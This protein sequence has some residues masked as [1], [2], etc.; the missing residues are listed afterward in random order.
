MSLNINWKTAFWVLALFIVVLMPV[1]S[2]DY[3]QSGDEW[4]QIDYGKD[5]WN[6]FAK[7]DQQALDYSNKSLQ[8][9]KQELYGGLFDF[10][11]EVI[12]RITP[13]VP[14]LTLR[15]FFNA[16][17]GAMLMLFTGLL[18]RRLSGKWEVAFLAL[19]FM[20]FSPR[21]FGESMNNPK[22]IPFATGFT[23]GVYAIV[24]FLQDFPKKAWRNAILLAI[25]WGIAFGVR[26]AG[27]I[28]LVGYFVLFTGLY[29]ITNKEL[30]NLL[31]A[32]KNKL[33]KKMLLVLFAGL[34][35]GYIIGLAAW[36]W[37]LQS[38]ISNTLAALEEMTNRSVVLK[39]LFEGE[40][41]PNNNMPWYYEFKWILMTSPLIIIA[42]IGIYLLLVKAHLKR[43]GLFAV[44]VPVFVAFFPLLYMIYKHSS[45]HDTWRHVFF[46]Y[47]GWVVMSAM[48]FDFL[49]GLVKQ[50]KLKMLP[51]GVAIIGLLPVV[52]W[53]VR[54]HPNQYVYFNEAVGG[55]KGAYGYYDLDYYQN[56]GKQ[57]ADW[58]LK[59]AKKQNGRQVVVLS[60][61]SAY[62][63][64]FESE[65]SWIGAD[66][67]RYPERHY[68][69]WDYYVAY[70]RY[71]S[72]EQMQND[73]WNLQNTV[74]KVDADGAPLCVVI[75]RKSRAGIAAFDALNKNDFATAVLKYQ[76]YLK[77]DT[78]DEFVYFNY[79]IALASV[80]QLD[81]A[82]SSIIKATTID[83]SKAEFFE[84]LAQI[85]K[86]K[87]DMQGSQNAMSNAQTIKQKEYENSGQE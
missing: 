55:P 63:K 25:G 80:G 24:A 33:L 75:E 35:G 40:Y 7:G 73:N 2:K 42:G 65:N 4:I 5:V 51:Q 34:A 20:L 9:Q 38:P 26:S 22:D 15:H 87:G 70:P 31:L 45:V 39:V 6:Y 79:G 61:M 46:V 78:T 54:S 59:H 10:S 69:E 44:I 50:E 30:R 71:I 37:G 74:F 1:L 11:M 18:A 13:S 28:L 3:G 86:A 83:P 58:I 64:Y 57:A 66:Y 12:H 62:N 21:I 14:E 85:Y 47:P 68:K 67:G 32:D 81:A 84:T 17:F 36:P 27:G 16:L 76:E 56:S 53:T 43:L 29:Y 49:S 52:I 77:S 48:G 72:A 8:F 41:K 60:N 82:V 23:I 19:L